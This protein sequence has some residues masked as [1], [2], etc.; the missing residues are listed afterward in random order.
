MKISVKGLDKAMKAEVAAFVKDLNLSTGLKVKTTGSAKAPIG[1]GLRPGNRPRRL[2]SRCHRF[3]HPHRSLGTAGLFYA[4]QTV[5]KLL[6]P[7]VV[8]G[9]IAAST[10][11]YSLPCLAIADQPHFGYRGFMLDVSRHFFTVD[12]VKKMLDMMSYYKLNKFHFHLTDDQGWRVQIDKYPKLTLFGAPHPRCAS[13]ICTPRP[14]HGSTSL[15]ARFS[16]PRMN[17][18]T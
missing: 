11:S 7:E 14:R 2:Y 13:P 3:R 6:G 12:E 8:L 5:K 16:T 9:K 18:A 15:T 10:R 4:F 1:C 17:S